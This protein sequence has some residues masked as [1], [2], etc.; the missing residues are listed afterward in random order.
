MSSTRSYDN[1]SRVDA[2]AVTRRRILDAARTLL[3][4]DGYHSMSVA[5]LARTAQVSPQTVYNAVGGKSD[6]VKAVYDVLLAG[7]ESPVPM[8]ERPE[9]LAMAATPDR[10]A[11]GRD[12]AAFAAGIL[13]RVGP[14]LGV[15]LAQGAGGDAGLAEF[16]ATIDRERRTGN[17]HAVDLLADT[18]GLAARRT[19]ES[20]VDELWTLTAPE[21][22]DRLVR[23]CGWSEEAYAVWLA[24]VLAAACARLGDGAGSSGTAR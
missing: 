7:D 4:E 12:Y 19:R 23:R 18:H 24:D 17:G 13:A 11:F 9:F 14:L 2:A 22:F 16:V 8:S 3:L 6:V 15:L 21:V 1:S 10:E 20:L 5:S